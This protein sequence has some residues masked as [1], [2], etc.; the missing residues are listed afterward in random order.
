MD[1]KDLFAV[2]FADAVLQTSGDPFA[3]ASLQQMAE[4]SRS[5]AEFDAK[6]DEAASQEKRPGDLGIEFLGPVL[7]VLLVTLGRELWASYCKELVEKG[8]KALADLTVDAIKGLVRRKLTAPGE[9]GVTDQ[10]VRDAAERSGLS[11]E[12][13]DA[14]ITTLHSPDLVQS[15]GAQG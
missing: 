11:A 13:I 4:E 6:L 1:D 5:S 8:G 12:Q 15:L 9:M 10:Q 3:A 14:L 2:W 7:P